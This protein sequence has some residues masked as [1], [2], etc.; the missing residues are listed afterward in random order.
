MTEGFD[1]VEH[2]AA[3]GID[4]LENIGKKTYNTL[5][6]HDPALR[7]TRQFLAPRGDKPNLSSSLREA[8]D[9]AEQQQKQDEANQEALKAHF[10]TL[11]DDYQGQELFF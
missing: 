2:L 9:Q 4:V 11:F 6:E 5:A 7:R 10:G 3:G 8:R 1:A